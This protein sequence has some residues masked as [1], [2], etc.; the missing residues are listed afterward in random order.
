MPQLRHRASDTNLALTLASLARV[1]AR[2][3]PTPVA[4]SSTQLT[5]TR[6]G[7][8]RISIVSWTR[9]QSWHEL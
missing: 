8:S 4:A 9:D 1:F 3:K 5:Q 7:L 6:H 2:L